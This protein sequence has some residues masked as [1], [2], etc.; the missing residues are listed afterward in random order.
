M[1]LPIS[2][3]VLTFKGTLDGEEVIIHV[4]AGFYESKPWIDMLYTRLDDQREGAED[5]W[6]SYLDSGS[7][8]NERSNPR[9]HT[10]IV[11][12][13]K[14]TRS[15]VTAFIEK[16][17]KI[18]LHGGTHILRFEK[19]ENRKPRAPHG[20][21]APPSASAPAAPAPAPTLPSKGN[22]A[23]SPFLMQQRSNCPAASSEPLPAP[24]PRIPSPD[25][26]WMRDS[27]MPDIE[28]DLEDDDNR[29]E[30][31]EF[32]SLPASPV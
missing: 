25:L 5:I 8:A 18:E 19:L 11:H 28:T 30:S 29:S 16:R 26:P 2:F 13:G 12:D 6:Q 3:R 10:S 20:N 21:W 32:Y 15:Q 14:E 24:K 9:S 22:E 4:A 7:R 31:P 1:N 17:S 23:G 27:P